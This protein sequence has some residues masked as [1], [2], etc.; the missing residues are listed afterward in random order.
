MTQYPLRVHSG[1]DTKHHKG[2]IENLLDLGAPIELMPMDAFT[3]MTTDA[4]RD[5]NRLRAK[6]ITRGIMVRS[7]SFLNLQEVLIGVMRQHQFR[8]GGGHGVMVSADSYTGKTTAAR[9]LMLDV[10]KQGIF[11]DPESVSRGDVLVSYVNLPSTGTPLGLYR[12]LAYYY[13]LPI[14][15]RETEATMEGMVQHAINVCNTQLVVI[16]DVHNLKYGGA[17]SRKVSAAIR[18]LG[19]DI[20][21]PILLMGV[22]LE[23]TNLLTGQEGAQIFERYRPAEMASYLSIKRPDDKQRWLRLVKSIIGAMPLFADNTQGL[24]A[25]ASELHSLTGGRIGPLNSIISRVALDLIEADDPENETIRVQLA[26]TKA[27]ELAHED[28]IKAAIAGRSGKRARGA[29]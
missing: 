24:R 9:I 7:D 11:E 17:H 4:R 12:M 14:G 21:C 16:D 20:N 1:L 15:A 27:D 28:R 23:R 10:V 6:A 29:A 22:A 13:G 19:D 3:G 5:F 18:R 8:E 25:F 2:Y 26:E